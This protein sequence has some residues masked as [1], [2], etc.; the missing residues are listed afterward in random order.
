MIG[1]DF[2]LTNAIVLIA[3]LTGI[4]QLLS[5]LREKSQRFEDLMEGVP[6]I[7]VDNG[8]PLEDRMKKVR[9]DREDVL[10]AAR[11]IHGLERMEQIKY[12]VL[13]KTGEISIIPVQQ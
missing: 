7:L 4:D 1:D 13:E 10:E 12:A 8:K 3:T 5:R 2:S 6:L 11:K 9:V